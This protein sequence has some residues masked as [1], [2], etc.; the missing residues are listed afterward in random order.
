MMVSASTVILRAKA[1]A[2]MALYRLSASFIYFRTRK[3]VNVRENI[4]REQS[5]NHKRHTRNSSEEPLRLGVLVHSRA[6]PV[7]TYV[8]HSRE[9][10]DGAD[11]EPD[12]SA[13]GVAGIGAQEAGAD[14]HPV[15]DDGDEEMGTGETGQEGKVD[16]GQRV[17]QEPVEVPQPE[18]LTI[19]IVMSVGDV[20]VVNCQNV[21][22]VGYAFASCEGEVGDEGDCRGDSD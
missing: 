16:E 3:K 21:M 12:P 15:G 6:A 10:T 14:H 13:G 5:L 9:V 18:D 1:P 19:D 17:C 4:H 20:L 22:F 2:A 11:G 8:I 7:H